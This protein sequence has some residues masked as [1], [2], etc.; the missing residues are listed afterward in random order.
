LLLETKHTRQISGEPF[1][2]WFSNTNLNLIV[3]YDAH[4]SITGFQLCYRHEGEEKALT[5][6]S[7]QGF[8]H[9]SI[10][11]GETRPARHKMTPILVPDGIFDKK[12]ITP[13]FESASQVLD[14]DIRTFV[15]KK[16]AEF[17]ENPIRKGRE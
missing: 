1:R 2:R 16:L 15:C 14:A 6:T 13:I 8:S 3:W 4:K 10:D 9:E 5:W 17:P 11:D 12:A 7:G